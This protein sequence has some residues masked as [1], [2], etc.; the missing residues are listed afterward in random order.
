[1]A[2]PFRKIRY[3]PRYINDSAWF[4]RP[5]VAEA[6]TEKKQHMAIIFY[7]SQIKVLKW[8]QSASN[9]TEKPKNLSWN[10]SELESPIRNK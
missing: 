4:S 8:V 6:A 7:F 3:T 10:L 9:I 1:M 5:H 2:L